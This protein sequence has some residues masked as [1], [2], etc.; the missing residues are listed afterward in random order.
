MMQRLWQ[1]L[2]VGGRRVRQR[3]DWLEM[4]GNNWVDRIMSVQV[5]DRFHAKQGRSTGRLILQE[6][7]KSLPVYL[8]R[9]YHLP[10]WQGLVAT[11]WPHAGLSPA[12]MEWRH[13]N[14]ARRQG[15]PVPEAVAAAEYVGPWGRLRSFLA[16]RELTGMLP[17]NE[18]IPRAAATLDPRTYCRWKRDLIAE[19]ARLTRELHSRQRFH[20]DFYLCHFYVHEDDLARSPHWFGRVYL[21]DLHR[22]ARHEWT[23]PIYQAKDLAQLLYSSELPDISP[24][25]RLRFWRYY[26]GGE[27]LSFPKRC[28]AWFIRLKWQR[29]RRHRLRKKHGAIAG[30]QIHG[31]PGKLRKKQY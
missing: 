12:F 29:Y 22:L 9:H 31:R 20:M 16:V 15:I 23:G 26:L 4:V 28:L 25:D 10:R 3:R 27:R 6:N 2:T 8:K 30:D 13:L 17:L 14:W 1:R 21:I 11:L 18:A 24:R 7:G 5:T 19:M